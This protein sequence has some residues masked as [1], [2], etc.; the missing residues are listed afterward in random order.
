MC[1][2]G[3]CGWMMMLQEVGVGEGGIVVKE[4]SV[5]GGREE[6]RRE[7]GSWEYYDTLKF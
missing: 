7:G 2:E 3:R 6:W 1:V 4:V 5:K